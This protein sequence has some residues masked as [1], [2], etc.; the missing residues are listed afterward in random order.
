MQRIL[1]TKKSLKDKSVLFVYIVGYSI[2][3]FFLYYHFGFMVS[4]DEYISPIMFIILLV[5]VILFFIY[6]AIIKYVVN[7][8]TIGEILKSRYLDNQYINILSDEE[9]TKFVDNLQSKVSVSASTFS[10]LTN[11]AFILFVLLLGFVAQRDMINK[12]NFLIITSVS[13]ISLLLSGFIGLLCLDKYDSAADPCCT[14][15]EKKAI[16]MKVYG[17]FFWCWCFLIIGVIVPLAL[18]RPLLIPIGYL[19]YIIIRSWLL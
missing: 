17:N 15:Y 16:R 7:N 13:L 11:L 14:T 3:V 12:P 4:L 2:V 8:Y 18:V 9:K 1:T 19:V 5:P 6:E 10:T